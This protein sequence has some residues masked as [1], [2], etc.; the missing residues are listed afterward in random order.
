MIVVKRDTVKIKREGNPEYAGKYNR[1]VVGIKRHQPDIDI[2]K[3]IGAHQRIR[4]M[5][6]DQKREQRNDGG[7]DEHDEAGAFVGVTHIGGDRAADAADRNQGDQNGAV[8]P[9]H[10]VGQRP[11]SDHNPNDFD[12]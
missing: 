12:E 7:D 11:K 2:Y 6:N 8:Y 1:L 10:Q 9:D 3:Q 4:V 5:V